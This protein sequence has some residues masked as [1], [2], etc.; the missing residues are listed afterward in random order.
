MFGEIN[1]S[2]KDK[3]HS[4]DDCAYTRDRKEK[5]GS[6]EL[7]EGDKKKPFNVNVLH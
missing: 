4:H 5:D 7:G 2:P 1:L 6:Q 3:C